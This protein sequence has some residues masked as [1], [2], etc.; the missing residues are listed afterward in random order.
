M[1]WSETTKGRPLRSSN[2]FWLRVRA[3]RMCTTPR[4]ASWTSC[5]AMREERSEGEG[6]AQ[7]F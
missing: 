6:P 2:P 5:M 4:A 7:L 3:V 1:L